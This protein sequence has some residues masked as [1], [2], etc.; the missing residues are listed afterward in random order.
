MRG[1]PKASMLPAK[2]KELMTR[3]NLLDMLYV[4]LYNELSLLMGG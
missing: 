4:V 1:S 3:M 2:I